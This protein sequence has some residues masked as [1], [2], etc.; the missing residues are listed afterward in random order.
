MAE[1][2]RV[3]IVTGASSGIGR[4]VAERLSRDGVAVVV[5]YS[6][7]QGRAEAVVSAIAAAGGTASA[8]GANIADETEAAALFAYAEAQY[9][10]VDVVVNAAGVMFLNPVA[11]I[12]FDDFDRML[13]VNVRGT[14]VITQLAARTVRRGGAIVNLSSTVPKLGLPTYSAY[15]ATKG[16]VDAATLVF[17]KEMRGRDVTVNAIAP[18]P[19]AS[20]LFLAGKP[21]EVIDTM[22]KAAPLERL[23]APEDTA[24]VVA[25]LTS[26]AGH[27]INGQIIRVNGGLI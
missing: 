22:A 23:G 5:G 4:A 20:P 19:T 9:G 1:V 15:S 24:E 13:T 11:E 2:T 8:F 14:F 17:A 26:R 25:F 18:G 12:T 16:A 21:Q 3:A 7:G 27:W 10:G 6:G